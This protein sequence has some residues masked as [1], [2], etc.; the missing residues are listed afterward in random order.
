MARIS[1][2]VKSELVMPHSRH[3]RT[4]KTCCSSL[5]PETSSDTVSVLGLRFDIIGVFRHGGVAEI[6]SGRR[7]H[8]RRA[9]PDIDSKSWNE[10]HGEV[11]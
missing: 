6:G 11:K 4:G 8:P 9:F 5:Q 3:R 2:R 1:L 7:P 10:D